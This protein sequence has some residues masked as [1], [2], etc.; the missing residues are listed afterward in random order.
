VT[1]GAFLRRLLLG[2]NLWALLVGV[3]L[4]HAGGASGWTLGVALSPLALLVL[5]S[6]LPLAPLTAFVF[7]ISLLAPLLVHAPLRG[8]QALSPVGA[9][10]VGLSL[11]TWAVG[12]GPRARV[13]RAWLAVALL[14]L[15][16]LLVLHATLL[17]QPLVAWLEGVLP[18]RVA[19]ARIVGALA[20]FV[21]WLVAAW[22]ALGAVSRRVRRRVT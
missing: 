5:A 1:L 11:A 7:P 12:G 13:A 9:A 22:A 18:G 20:G 2:A 15:A 4:L 10:V 21:V 19:E 3:P 16:L 8:E 6:A 14:V 17:L